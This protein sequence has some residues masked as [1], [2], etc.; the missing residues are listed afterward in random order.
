MPVARSRVSCRPKLDLPSE[1]RRFR[2]DLNPRKSRLLSV[3]SNFACCASPVC[4]PTLDEFL[5]QFVELPV[6]GHLLDLLAQ[7]LVEHLAIHQRLL[8]GASKFV[9]RLFAL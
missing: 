6:R 5:D 3:I 2:S 1:P 8:N 7:V 4:P 9:E